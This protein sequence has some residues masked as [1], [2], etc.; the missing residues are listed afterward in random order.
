MKGQ[1]FHY[2]QALQLSEEP[3]KEEKKEEEKK[4]GEEKKEGEGKAKEGAKGDA[5]PPNGCNPGEILAADGNCYFEGEMV[6]ISNKHNKLSQM[7]QLSK[8]GGFNANAEPEKVA[9]LIPENYRTLSNQSS[10]ENELNY[11]HARTA[12]FAQAGNKGV[13]WTEKNGQLPPER[14]SIIEPVIGKS[15]TTFYT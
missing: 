1:P 14:V 10:Q 15:Q 13:Q 12:F 9:D 11:P 6:K 7:V 3:A 5:P 4:D 8:E 2:S